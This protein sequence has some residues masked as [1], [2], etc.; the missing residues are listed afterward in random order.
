M[1]TNFFKETINE[2]ELSKFLEELD[3]KTTHK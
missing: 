2:A 3:E 1:K